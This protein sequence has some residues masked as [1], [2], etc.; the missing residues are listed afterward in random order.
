LQCL[1]DNSE[2]CPRRLA[3]GCSNE[4]GAVCSVQS[5]GGNGSPAIKRA[6]SILGTAG[7]K[8]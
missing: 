2:L 1:S 4:S 3:S 8:F 6:D 7:C 5:F